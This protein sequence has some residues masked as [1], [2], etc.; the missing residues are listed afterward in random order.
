MKN[1]NQRGI[2]HLLV[3]VLIAILA[4]SYFGIDL[5]EVFS[6]PLLKKNLVFTWTKTKEA[7]ENYVYNP[8]SGI[9]DK[10]TD[11]PAPEETAEE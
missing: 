4:I 2:I 1:N 3:M 9:F 10:K 6:R 8:I 7:W 5:E 11:E